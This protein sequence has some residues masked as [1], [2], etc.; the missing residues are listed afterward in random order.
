MIISDMFVFFSL[1][2][3]IINGKNATTS[4]DPQL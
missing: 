1:M 3:I 2:S 4:V